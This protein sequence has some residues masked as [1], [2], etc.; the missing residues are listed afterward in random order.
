MPSA[1]DV[2]AASF[3]VLVA[4][5]RYGRHLPAAEAFLN[6]YDSLKVRPPLAFAS[7]NLTARKPGK[8]TAEG[9]AYLRK[10]IA[11]H[12]LAPTLAVAFAGKLDYAR[13]RWRDRQIIRF[14]MLLTGGPTDPSTSI[15]FT[16]WLA[17]DEFAVSVAEQSKSA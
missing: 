14:I 12:R 7:V 5:V 15:D 9:N 13:Y 10:T 11:R 17:V 6:M 1:A 8:T 2:E 4:A 16:S 3:V